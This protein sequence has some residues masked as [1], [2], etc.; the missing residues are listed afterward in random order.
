MKPA[1]SRNGGGV[2]SGLD[3]YCLFMQKGVKRH[4]DITMRQPVIS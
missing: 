4:S 3:A 2:D 1:I